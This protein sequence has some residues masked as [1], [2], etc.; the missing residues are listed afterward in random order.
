MEETIHGYHLKAPFQNRDAGFSRW[1]FATKNGREFFLK[2]FLNPVYPLNN[3]MGAE[4]TETARQACADYERRNIAIYRAV[5]A[6]SDGNLVRVESFFRNESHYYIA[7]ERVPSE[8][9]SVRE[10][11][12][13][14]YED[15]LRLC[16][17]IAHSVLC[18]HEKGIVH[19]DI[20][21]TNILLKRTKKRTVTAKLVDF[22]CSF[23]VDDPPRKETDLNGDQVYLSPEACRFFFGEQVP[24][25]TRM[26]VFSLG[27][28]FHEYLTGELP[29]FDTEEYDYLHEA[30]LDGQKAGVSPSIPEKHRNMIEQM[31]VE[32]PAK[33]IS[34]KEVCDILRPE[35]LQA[36]SGG[37]WFSAAG[38][39]A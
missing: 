4:L 32:D 39:L 15:R 23:S 37:N 24:L 21:D 38:D 28:L 14:P 18:L 35:S 9:K 7:M 11:A 20:K 6:A 29:K 17:I 33:R 27:I 10:I 1:T 16:R 25:T 34:M 19:A 3:T 30:V 26:D 31:L 8:R 12:A 13:F 22:D 36:V 5:N 2:E